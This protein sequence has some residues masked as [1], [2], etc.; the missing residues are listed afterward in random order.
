MQHSKLM[1]AIVFRDY[2]D[3][4]EVMELVEDCE[5]PKPNK[6][7][8]L[9]KIECASVNAADRYIVRANYFIIRMVFGLFKPSKKKRILGMDI[10]GTIQDIGK[11]VKGFQVGDAVVADIRK[12]FGGG[13]AQFAIV[14]A[15]HLVKKPEEVSF[16]QACT[17]PIS[18]QAAM[19][20]MILC[21]IKPGDKVLVNGASGGVGSIGIQ[22]AK[23]QGAYVA[24]I[25]S[26]NKVDAVKSWGAD[27]I[28]DYTKK[29]SIK[30][31]IG[32]EFDAVFDTASFQCPGRYKQILKREGK[33]V[34]VGGDFYNMLKIKLFG[35][36]GR[37]SQ[38]F[39]AL[40]QKVEVTTNIKTVLEMIAD[41]KIKPAIQKVISLQ[42]VPDAIHSLEQR[43]V[44]GKIVVDLNKEVSAYS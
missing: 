35:R 14:N 5:I 39:M 40:T 42:G 7:E 37:G 1:R 36:F 44:V 25:C 4:R 23:A 15:K 9:V 2:G 43:T 13:Y 29:D 22:I 26:T 16:E 30:A 28:V 24:A 41:N 3:P 8:V 17:V 10:A 20:G 21:D 18:G 31:L 11:N 38:K 6:N 27:E 33:Y 34:L 12:S 32:N 19:M